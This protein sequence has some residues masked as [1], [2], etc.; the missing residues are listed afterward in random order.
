MKKVLLLGDSIRMNYQEYVKE[1][2]KDECEV[3]YAPDNGRFAAYTLW[4]MNQMFRHNDGICLV[5][6]NNGYWDMNIEPPMTEA[7][8]PIDEYLHYLRRIAEYIRQHGAKTIFATT[9]PIVKDGHALDTTGTSAGLMFRNE[10]V[11][12]YNTAAKKLM[13]E[14]NIPV[15]DLYELCYDESKNH[16][17]CEDLLHLSEEGKV[18]CAEQVAQMI[19][20]HLD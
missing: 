7:I 18:R 4:Q 12:E 11:V 6:W 5:H 10:W 19:R 13:Q 3:I 2:L 16:Y 17:K 14:L 9:I 8:H 1:L 20:K 15:N